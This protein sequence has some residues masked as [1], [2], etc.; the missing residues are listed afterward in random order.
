MKNKWQFEK[1]KAF[2]TLLSEGRRGG[3]A[4]LY[5]LAF[6]LSAGGLHS[7]YGF[8]PFWLLFAGAAVLS[9]VAALLV[10]LVFFL[11][12]TT[13][14]LIRSLFYTD[15]FLMAVVLIS[16]C[17]GEQVIFNV[18]FAVLFVSATDLLGRSFYAF[19]IAKKRKGS[20][21]I[22]AIA[23]FVLLSA[24]FLFLL[25]EGFTHGN[26]ERYRDMLEK[27]EAP[28]GFEASVSEQEFEVHSVTYGV[29]DGFDLA[30]ESYDLSAF[31]KRGF[32]NKWLMKLCFDHDV[33]QTPLSGK[34]W[35]PIDGKNCPV[36]FIVHGNHD[37]SAPSYLGYEYIGE[38]LAGFGYVVVSVDEN[39]CNS[40][41]KEND[42]RA[43]LLLENV[44]KILAWN[45][46]TSSPLYG[47]L[48]PEKIALAGHSR[49]G[50]CVSI[51]ALFNQYERYPDN[52]NIRFDYNFHICSLIAIAPT[53]DQYQPASKY[54][55]L[56]DISYLLIHGSNDQDVT[57]VMG[58]KMYN[59]IRFSGQE[60]AFCSF[61]YLIGANHGQFNSLW[62]RYD[63]PFPENTMLSVSDLL[64]SNE[65]KA[66]LCRCLKTFLDVTVTGHETYRSL[67]CDPAGYLEGAYQA[68]YRDNTFESI[69]DF[70]TP[71]D[72]GKGEK[73]QILVRD[74]KAWTSK[75]RNTSS[76]AA[77]ENYALAFYWEE[78]EEKA[79]E[80]KDPC[81]VIN[82]QLD[83]SDCVFTFNLADM[84]EKKGIE[85]EGPLSY[86]VTFT[87][88]NNKK[89]Q[90]KSPVTVLPTVCVQ[91]FKPDVLLHQ[92]EY[93]HQ[94]TTVRI[95]MD[96]CMADE[97]FDASDIREIRIGFEGE[98]GDIEIDDIGTCKD[99]LTDTAG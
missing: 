7:L 65:Q 77:G 44:K 98:A 97:G 9:A 53:V 32:V 59:H 29:G 5:C 26:A 31:E 91:L 78:D 64:D 33:D 41:S 49:G 76:D 87:D 79:D 60:K 66:V 57:T 42:A 94:F 69:F 61:L 34:I 35:Y 47:R 4:L 37:I 17:L 72:P 12:F 92:Y 38:Y 8:L 99:P 18:L 84:R 55:E 43:I 25:P 90:I 58:E 3:E 10:W 51:A 67:F 39:Y 40:L 63:M 23:S 80:G 2:C 48:D 1:T 81:V 19:V 21:V 45:A 85:E 6:L 83:L 30:S 15:I 14:R 74:V 11:L 54:V 62:E 46:D 50:E 86:S 75:R 36:L 16:G 73:E 68:M 71:S 27:K 88:A 56:T 24:A 93:K 22:T 96:D 28:E 52:G 20:L 70:D 95:R 13:K 82:K 89:A